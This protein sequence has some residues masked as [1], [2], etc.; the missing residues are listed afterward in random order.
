MIAPQGLRKGMLSLGSN[1]DKPGI[2][3]PIEA[4]RI[5]FLRLDAQ[6]VSKLATGDGDGWRLIEKALRLFFPQ[7]CHGALPHFAFRSA[8]AFRPDVKKLQAVAEVVIHL[9]FHAVLRQ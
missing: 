6:S 3:T 7:Q 8:A 9:F 4:H 1:G 2:T 5:S